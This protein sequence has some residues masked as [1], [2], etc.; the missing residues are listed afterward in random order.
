[1]K[2]MFKDTKGLQIRS[3]GRTSNKIMTN[4]KDKKTNMIQNTICRKLKVVQ[5][6][7]LQKTG[8]NFYIHVGD[9]HPNSSFQM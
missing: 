5:N 3:R 7:T 8:I 6:E 4:E 2:K 9:L 1:V